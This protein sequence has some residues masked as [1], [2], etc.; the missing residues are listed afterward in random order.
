MTYDDEAKHVEAIVFN[1]L[2]VFHC[3]QVN[4]DTNEGWDGKFTQATSDQEEHSDGDRAAF[5]LCVAKNETEGPIPVFL[6]PFSR[7]VRSR[8]V[9]GSL[10]L[11][12]FHFRVCLGE[13]LIDLRGLF[14]SHVF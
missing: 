14:V 4:D 10:L 7:L 11:L 1:S 2:K 3:E 9:L 5:A 6:G 13:E 8:L 12:S